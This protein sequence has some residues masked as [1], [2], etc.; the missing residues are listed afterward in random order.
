MH[1]KVEKPYFCDVTKAE[2]SD[3]KCLYFSEKEPEKSI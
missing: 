3:K 1:K 2:K